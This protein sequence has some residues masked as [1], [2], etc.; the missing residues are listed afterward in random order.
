M[1]PTVARLELDELLA[2]L[3]DRAQ[4]VMATQGRLR[5]LLRAHRMVTADL[6]LPTLLRLVVEAACDLLDARYGALGVVA[7][8][9]TL[10]EF[11]HVG[12]DPADVTR[13]GHLPTGQGVLGVLIDDPHPRRVDDIARDPNAIG[14]PPGHPPMHTF[15]GVPITVRGE[16]FGNLYLTEKRDGRPFTA[17]DEEL[18]L[19]LAVTAGVAIDNARLFDEA[20]RRHQWM[21]ASAE[22]THELMTEPAEP[23]DLV[24]ERARATAHADYAAMITR[25]DDPAAAVVEVAAGAD[26]A[27]NA[28]PLDGSL[29]GR[30]LAEQHPVL[31]DDAAADAC[32][33][34]RGPDIGCLIALPLRASTDADRRVLLLGRAHGRQVFTAPD[35]D[36]ASSFAGHVAVALELARSKS[37]RERLVVLADR[38]RIARDLHDHVIQRMFAVALGI[39]DVA[40]YEK[41]A[42]ADRL[43]GFVEDIDATIK[44]IRRSI[45][46]LRGTAQLGRGNLRSAVEKIAADAKAGLG[47]APTVTCAGPLDTVVDDTLAAHLLAVVRE[48]VSNA[49][50]HAHATALRVS[51]RLENDEIVI[52]AEDDGVGIGDAVRSSGLTNL[53]ERADSLGGTFRLTVPTGGGTHLRWTAPI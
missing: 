43:N 50:R 24:V 7:P 23:I 31:T 42:N 27:G 4:D 53:R 40:Q 36:M 22:V 32:D 11:V 18:A 28:V 12:I 29:T 38:G 17:E 3:V 26:T 30:V 14:F 48:A 46:E 52:D 2:Q 5:G 13:I 25:G 9:R 51:V 21:R 45:F 37:E 34:E 8:D 35:L 47:F 16:V 33:L 49:A 39:Q 1:F 44:D 10:E 41:T 20:Q 15:L 19:A 6:R